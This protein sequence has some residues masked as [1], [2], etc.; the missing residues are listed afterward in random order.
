[1]KYNLSSRCTIVNY[2]VEWICM[3]YFQLSIG[4]YLSTLNL[5]WFFFFSFRGGG[6]GRDLISQNKV[7]TPAKQRNIKLTD[8]NT[9]EYL[10]QDC[11]QAPYAGQPATRNFEHQNNSWSQHKVRNLAHAAENP[12]SYFVFNILTPSNSSPNV[13][14]YFLNQLPFCTNTSPMWS[15]IPFNTNMV[16]LFSCI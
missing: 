7:T 11:C 10:Y 5:M 14:T 15:S 8:R 6:G 12:V 9:T 2:Q 4:V 13:L 3:K 16:D 1:M